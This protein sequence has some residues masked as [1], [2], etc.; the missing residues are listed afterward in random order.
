MADEHGRIPMS[1]ALQAS[2]LRARAYASE[3][4][5]PQV[6]LEH[7]LLA[8]SED[9]DASQVMTSCQVD[10]GRLR[11]DV[12]GFLGSQTERVPGGRSEPGVSPGVTQILKYATLAAAQARRPRIDGAIVLAAIVGEARSMAA[13]FL[14]SQSLTFEAAIK[15]LQAAAPAPQPARQPVPQPAS[16]A[17]QPPVPPSMPQPLDQRPP[18][19]VPPPPAP[20]PAGPIRSGTN[21]EDILAAARTRVQSRAAGGRGSAESARSDPAGDEAFT[22]ASPSHVMVPPEEPSSFPPPGPGL[23]PAP[24]PQASTVPPAELPPAP[25]P[26]ASTPEAAAGPPPRRPAQEESLSSLSIGLRQAEADRTPAA[27]PQTPLGPASNTL[28][29]T[30]DWLMPARPAAPSPAPPLPAV[31]PALPPAVSSWSP[32]P[33]PPM[34]S[35]AAMAGRTSGGV[36]P[37]PQAPAQ[38]GALPLEAPLPQIAQRSRLPA[39]PAPGGSGAFPTLERQRIPMPPDPSISR[40]VTGPPAPGPHQPQS[41]PYVPPPP[42]GNPPRQPWPGGLGPAPVAMRGGAPAPA[43]SVDPVQEKS[44]APVLEPG[45]VSH[46]IPNRMTVSA[47]RPIE[48]RVARPPL[49]TSSSTLA[50]AQPDPLSVRAVSVRLRIAKGAASIEAQSPETQWD[51]ARAGVRPASDTAVWRF[52]VTPKRMGTVEIAVQVF[53]RVMASDGVLVETGL[54][55]QIITIRVGRNLMASARS[56]GRAIVWMAA[57][58]LALGLA[59][60]ATKSSVYLLLRR[61]IP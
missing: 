5:H 11:N 19:P 21:A 12:A 28:S 59:E 56:W 57:G 42:E 26:L 7:L 16:Q 29:D 45:H 61:L 60:L 32:T 4:A 6:L 17:P 23:Q 40:P 47:S 51:L 55:E 36:A 20:G 22:D 13:A 52:A 41:R 33:L 54:P 10:L 35:R 2:L 58:G 27:R 3:Q 30:P 34:P 25:P 18:R 43:S 8:L 50:A 37:L 9:E 39:G 46:S 49:S 1:P 24:E 31:E 44:R 14:K 53:A 48:I 38:P 15:A